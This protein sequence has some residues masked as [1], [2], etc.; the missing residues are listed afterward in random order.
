[1]ALGKLV[2]FVQTSLQWVL[3]ALPRLRQG[4]RVARRK[5]A[6]GLNRVADFTRKQASRVAPNTGE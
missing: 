5:A 2:R 4:G 3:A 6:G 1:M